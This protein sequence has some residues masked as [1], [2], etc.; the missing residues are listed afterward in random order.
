MRKNDEEIVN[1]FGR[2]RSGKCGVFHAGNGG[3]DHYYQSQF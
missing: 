2:C 1:V 3:T